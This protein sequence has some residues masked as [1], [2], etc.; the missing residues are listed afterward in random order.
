LGG[1]RDVTA[2]SLSKEDTMKTLLKITTAISG[3]LLMAGSISGYAQDA[4][5][6]NAIAKTLHQY[7]TAMAARDVQALQ[8]VL[9]STFIVV[10]AGGES[11]R[12]HVLNA[13]DTAKLLPPEGND[14]WQNLQVTDLKVNVS[15]T[16]PSVATVSY[17]VFHPLSPNQVNALEQVLKAPAAPLDESQRHE[18]SRRLTDKGSR[19]SECAMLA[20]RDGRWRIVTISV[21]K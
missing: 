7:Y 6:T 1:G 10:E 9:D 11:S 13:T 12:T 19:E 4:N 14:D 5:A 16:H 20:L 15:G 21:P 3:C 18:V 8:G 17:T 2:A